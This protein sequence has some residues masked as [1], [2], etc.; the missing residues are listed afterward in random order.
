MRVISQDGT[1]DVPYEQVIIQQYKGKIYFLNKNLTG[2]EQLVRDMESASYSTEAKAIKAMEMLREQYKRLEVLKILA[3]GA[4][5][6]MGKTLKNDELVECNRA[7][8]DM[9]VFQFPQDDEIEV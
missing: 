7:Y 1:I 5:E 2:V 8:R 9:N 4:A 3:S 6:H